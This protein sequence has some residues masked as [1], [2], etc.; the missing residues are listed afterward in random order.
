MTEYFKRDLS[1]EI[2]IRRV[3]KNPWEE[4]ELWN[5]LY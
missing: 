1:G 4:S 5:I 3:E 2:R